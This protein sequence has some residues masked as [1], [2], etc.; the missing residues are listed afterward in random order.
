MSYG[1]PN[2]KRLL[3][4]SLIA[5]TLVSCIAV[6][7]APPSHSPP[8]PAPAHHP[9]PPAH[10]PPPPVGP[11]A[12]LQMKYDAALDL[13][14]AASRKS[15]G[16]M[17]FTEADLEKKT[18]EITGHFGKIFVRCTMVRRSHHTYLTFYFRINDPRADARIP[19]DYAAKCH[20]F[21][22]KELKEEG[23]RTD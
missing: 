21:V 17:K 14:Y 4:P 19:G 18:G 12:S 1:G 3:L 8:P 16:L 7:K 9:P 11:D 5:G 13:C 23:R 10:H 20:A 2:M 15:L 22:A 6:V